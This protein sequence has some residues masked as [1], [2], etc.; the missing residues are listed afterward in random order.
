VCI[1]VKNTILKIYLN[2]HNQTIA[3]N[4]KSQSGAATHKTGIAASQRADGRDAATF[5]IFNYINNI[6]K[7]KHI[8]N[9]KLNRHLKIHK[10]FIN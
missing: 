4:P 7:Y 6:I 3:V 1:I 2:F 8:I 5:F 9:E 10:T